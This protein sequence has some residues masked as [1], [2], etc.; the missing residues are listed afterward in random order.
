MTRSRPLRTKACRRLARS[1]ASLVSG[2]V[3][4]LAL[5]AYTGGR[6]LGYEQHTDQ[7]ASAGGDIECPLR[8]ESDLV[9]H[10]FSL[11]RRSLSTPLNRVER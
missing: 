10:G 9:F 5:P 7:T 3:G 2:V 8:G 1:V 6:Q 4:G 11:A